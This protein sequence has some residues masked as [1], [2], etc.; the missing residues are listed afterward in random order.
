[1]T[2]HKFLFIVRHRIVKW[3]ILCFFLVSCFFLL[4]RDS[5]FHETDIFIP[6]D[7]S[8]I[9]DGLSITDPPLKGIEV[10]IRSF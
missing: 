7:F 1:M 8:K 6:I 5:S 3:V 2:K 9:P 4:W 10:H